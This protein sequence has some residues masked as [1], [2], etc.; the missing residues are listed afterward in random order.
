MCNPS[1][2]DM[3]SAG[4]IY[5]MNTVSIHRGNNA[6]LPHVYAFHSAV[7]YYFRLSANGISQKKGA[8]DDVLHQK[9]LYAYHFAFTL[10]IVYEN[11]GKV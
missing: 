10:N 7:Q 1:G 11:G 6:N 4:S 5:P 9:R 8:F 3:Q 2:I